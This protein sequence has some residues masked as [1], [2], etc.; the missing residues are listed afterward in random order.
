MSKNK[1]CCLNWKAKECSKKQ[2]P[3]Y[4]VNLDDPPEKRWSHIMKDFKNDFPKVVKFIE[5][6]SENIYG[7]NF[8][9]IGKYFSDTV[10]GWFIKPN[11]IKELEGISKEIGIG[12]GLLI[13]VQISYELCASCTTVIAQDEFGV[14]YHVRTMDWMITILKDFTIEVDFQQKGTTLYKATT[15]AGYIGI[16]TGMKPNAFSVS[17]NYRE[18]G[19]SKWNNFWNLLKGSWSIG[20]LVRHTLENAD[21]YKDAVKMFETAKLI[22]P[23]YI[24][25]C[26][27]QKNEGCL[28]TRSRNLSENFISLGYLKSK[29][30]DDLVYLPEKEGMLMC[31]N[32]D[33]WKYPHFSEDEDCFDSLGRTQYMIKR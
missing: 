20:Y 6:E 2:I 9:S 30:D 18:L 27:V 31:T 12:V 28:I 19:E 5:E 33:W 16:L 7:K 32:D 17:I 29:D 21:S 14:P 10:V 11:L 3:Q 13:L 23:V 22:A 15:W 4:I 24:N 25:V 8:T 26:G 1:N